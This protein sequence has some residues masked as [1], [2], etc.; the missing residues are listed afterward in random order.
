MENIREDRENTLN[1][2]LWLV[3]GKNVRNKFGNSK[4]KQYVNQKSGSVPY[5]SV[6]GPKTAND[7]CHFSWH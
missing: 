7:I 5:V 6:S 1:V 4:M 2:C 3:G